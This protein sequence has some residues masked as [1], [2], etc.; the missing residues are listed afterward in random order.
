MAHRFAAALVGLPALNQTHLGELLRAGHDH[1]SMMSDMQDGFGGDKMERTF[2]KY[3]GLPVGAADLEA[4][5]WTKHTG[6]CDPHLGY[7]W[8]EDESGP[9]KKKP[10]K[11]YTT[12]G[13]QPSGVGIIIK[14]YGSEPLPEQQKKWATA[15]PLVASNEG[16]AVHID[17]AFRAGAIVCSGEQDDAAPIGD[18]LIVNPTASNAENRKVLPLTEAGIAKD[19]WRRGSCFDGMGWHWFLDTSLGNGKLSWKAENLFP[20]VT[21]YDQGQINAIFFASTINQVSIPL[22]A[23]NE[24]EPKSLSNPEMCKNLCDDECTFEGLTSAG[25]WSTAHVYFRDHSSVTCPASLKC[26]LNWPLPRGSCCEPRD[27]MV[28]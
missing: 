8:T 14:G 28:V 21:M 13:G 12:A 15:N 23:T 18:T 20:V 17:V 25:P 19:G 1:A 16:D 22:L 26:G 11:L 24:W 5:G 6:E 4:R 7:V 3:V 27:E 10:M 9:T 2:T